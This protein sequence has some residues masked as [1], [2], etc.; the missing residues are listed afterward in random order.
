MLDSRKRARARNKAKVTY[1]LAGLIYCQCGSAMTGNSSSYRT[2]SGIVRQHYYECNKANRIG[3]CHVGKIRKELVEEHVLTDM[4]KVLFSPE[5]I[6]TLARRLHE[7]SNKE[8]GE[9]ADALVHLERE[10]NR[11]NSQI[12]NLVTVLAEGAG[13]Q[14]SAIVEKLKSLENQKKAMAD[15]YQ[16]L[17][18]RCD[19]QSLDLSAITSY[20]NQQAQILKSGNPDACR[21]LINTFV[22]RVNVSPE[23]TEVI[24]KI[25]TVVFAGGGGGSRTHRPEERP[26]EAATS[27]GCIFGFAP[28]SPTARL[29]GN[30]LDECPA[31]PPRI[32]A[33]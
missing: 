13:A 14:V 2:S 9:A 15:E 32:G 23:N 25:T 21:R 30:Y 11:L 18:A 5:V 33:G 29:R 24:Y 27:V 1:L 19:A 10:M 12:E 16:K 7:H 20:L 28:A 6:P 22:E 8:R 26:Q 17:K 4:E 3:T 31:A